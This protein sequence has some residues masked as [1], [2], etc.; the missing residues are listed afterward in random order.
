[1][2]VVLPVN[3]LVSSQ[4]IILS[5]TPSS[6]IKLQRAAAEGA[7]V[8]GWLVLQTQ[9]PLQAN[10][11]PDLWLALLGV[12]KLIEANSMIMLVSTMQTTHV[13]F[14]LIQSF[15]TPFPLS[16]SCMLAGLTPGPHSSEHEVVLDC[17]REGV[18]QLGE[19]A[20]QHCPA[21]SVL[22]TCV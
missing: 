18:Q 14:R 12:Y 17:R 8:Q 22:Q 4:H 15:S 20:C 2:G 11:L 13:F 1:M 5:S 16:D 21:S 9:S 3:T 6:G 19:R 10:L 7:S